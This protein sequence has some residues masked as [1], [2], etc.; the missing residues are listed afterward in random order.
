MARTRIGVDTSGPLFD[1]LAQDI[2]RDWL[3]E[4]K[5]EV[6]DM[7]VRELDAIIMDKSGRGTG[8]YQSMITT[9]VVRYND[10]LI[11]DP[12]IYGPW[13]EGVSRRNESTRFKGYRLWR[14]TRLRLR[15]TYKDVAQ[16]KLEEYYLRRMGGHT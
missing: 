12:V 15:R 14:R 7:G 16:K 5:R 11:T 13:L 8:H 1:N 4:T 10:V 3:D 2:V 6:A 9:R